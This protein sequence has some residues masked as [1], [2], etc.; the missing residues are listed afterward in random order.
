MSWSHYHA[1][2][3]SGATVR[4]SSIPWLAVAG[5][6]I[7]AASFGLVTLFFPW[8]SWVAFPDLLVNVHFAVAPI[9]CLAI[10]VALIR[11]RR[12]ALHM[13]IAGAAYIGLPNLISGSQSLGLLFSN[14]GSNALAFWLLAYLMGG[15]GQLVVLLACLHRLRPMET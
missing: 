7:S 1:E 10:A 12:F 6:F 14:P 3:T 4:L 9:L 15:L 8:E 11:R 2:M 5:E 13:G